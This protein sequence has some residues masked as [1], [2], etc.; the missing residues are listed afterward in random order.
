MALLRADEK[1]EAG[2]APSPE[3]MARMGAFIAELASAGSLLATDGLQP[4][5][6]GARIKLQ[7]GTRSVTDGPFIESKELV[8]SYAILQT[9]S[10]EEA[11]EIASRFLEILGEGELELRLISEPAALVPR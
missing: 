10:K 4:S 8:A 6:K 7:A 11:V 9:S 3:L 5:A 2:V 1:S